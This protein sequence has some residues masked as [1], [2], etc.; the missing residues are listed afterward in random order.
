MSYE[1]LI[2]GDKSQPINKSVGKIRK[3]A[4]LNHMP[5]PRLWHHVITNNW[6]E[7]VGTSLLVGKGK[8]SDDALQFVGDALLIFLRTTLQKQL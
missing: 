6:L 5:I 7:N 1:W 2:S 8:K 4:K 3:H